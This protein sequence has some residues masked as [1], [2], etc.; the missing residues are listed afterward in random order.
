VAYQQAVRIDPE[1][2]DAHYNLGRYYRKLGRYEDAIETYDQAIEADPDH[3]A[4]YFDLGMLY[5]KLEEFENGERSFNQVLRINPD[6]APTLHYMGLIY[7]GMGRYDDAVESCNTTWGL[8]MADWVKADK[9]WKPLNRRSGL[10]RILP[11]PIII[12][13]LS[14]SS[15]AIR[16]RPWKNIKF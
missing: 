13:G 8:H 5:G 9:K 2:A 7:N 11:R 4:S 16:Q 1:N 3:A 15:T 10:I 6:H 12:W 14:T